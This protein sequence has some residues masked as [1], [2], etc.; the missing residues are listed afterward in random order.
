MKIYIRML[1]KTLDL[2]RSNSDFGQKLRLRHSNTD[3]NS[4]FPFDVLVDDYSNYTFEIF[5][6]D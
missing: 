6:K 1:D 4:Q 3:F 2:K 5:M